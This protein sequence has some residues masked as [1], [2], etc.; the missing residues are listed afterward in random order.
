MYQKKSEIIAKVQEYH[1]RVAEIYHEILGKTQDPRITELALELHK[2]EKER[3]KYLE[4]H[5]EVAKAMNCWLEFPCEELSNQIDDCLQKV[6]G[7]ENI[8]MSDMLQTSMHFDNCLLKLYN[9]LSAENALNESAANIFY[10]M[11][12]KTK[13]EQLLISDMLQEA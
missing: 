11:L 1:N 4:K 9:I 7:I 5:F 10:Y 13:K 6:I 3:A 12:K 8:K 2:F